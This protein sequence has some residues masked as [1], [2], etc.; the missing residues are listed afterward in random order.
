[1]HWCID[2]HRD[3]AKALRPHDAVFDPDWKPG[4]DRNASGSKLI[5]DYHIH[6]NHLTDCS[7]CHR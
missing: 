2:C 7:I 5:A 1:M 4:G 3:P 6:A